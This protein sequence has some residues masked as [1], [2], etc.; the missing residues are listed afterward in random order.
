MKIYI[1]CVP[2]QI[3]YLGKKLFQ[4]Y[5]PKHSAIQ[6]AGFLNQA[7]LQRKAMKQPNFF[8]VDTNSQKLNWIEKF[9]VE[10]GQ[11]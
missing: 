2:A 9:L 1:C 7:F 10:H 4:R 6:V 5:Q 8:N 3:L 11:K